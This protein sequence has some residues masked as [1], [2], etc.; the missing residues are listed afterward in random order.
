MGRSART[1]IRP[2]SPGQGARASSTSSGRS[3]EGDRGWGAPQGQR[4]TPTGAA[5]TEPFR[6]H[7]VS[8][9]NPSYAKSAMDEHL[10][11]LLDLSRRCEAGEVSDDDV[12]VWWG[13]VRSPNRQQPLAHTPDIRSLGQALASDESEETQLY[14]TDYRSLYVADVFD[15]R[16]GDL[17]PG[18]EPHIPPYYSVERLSCDFWFGVADIR[19]LVADDTLAVVQELRALRNVHYNDRPVSIYGGMVDLPFLVTRPD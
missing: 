17:A 1:A 14:L 4:M 6:R 10:T 3:V 5:P 8:V 2:R 9:W 7:L 16:E 13:K 11:L 19:R 12:Y 18:E 15:V